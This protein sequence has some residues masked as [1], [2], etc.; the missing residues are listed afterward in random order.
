MNKHT[1]V[2]VILAPFL[3]IGGYIASGYYLDEKVREPRLLTL[4]QEAACDMST[5]PCV[6]KATGLTFQLSHQNGQTTVTSSVGM[7]TVTIAFV[8][9]DGTEAAYPLTPADRKKTWTSATQY[10]QIRLASGLDTT[11]RL[12][13][14]IENLTYIHQFKPGL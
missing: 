7:A 13:A 6:L 5:I 10:E 2:A 14:T 3:A 8:K 12:A 1:R 9:S 4:N 11:I